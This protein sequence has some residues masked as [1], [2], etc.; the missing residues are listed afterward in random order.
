MGLLSSILARR[1]TYQRNQ[2]KMI[3]MVAVEESKNASIA[4]PLGPADAAAK[5]NTV[6]ANM[7]PA[8]QSGCCW[9]GGENTLNMK[10]KWSLMS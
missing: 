4:L 9:C 3:S 2:P 1:I 5:P 8:T 6:Q 10:L 7:R